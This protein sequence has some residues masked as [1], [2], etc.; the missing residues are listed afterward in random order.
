M[1]CCDHCEIMAEGVKVKGI[2]IDDVYSTCSLVEDRSERKNE[3]EFVVCELKSI[4]KIIP[5]RIYMS[6]RKL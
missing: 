1:K 2:W 3:N 6:R 5:E 4:E